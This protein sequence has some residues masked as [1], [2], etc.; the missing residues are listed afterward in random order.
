MN[1]GFTKHRPMS[2]FFVKDEVQNFH[3]FF[4]V[5]AKLGLPLKKV[6]VGHVKVVVMVMVFI[7]RGVHTNIFNMPC[8]H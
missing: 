8:L 5:Y 4:V 1:L 7:G 2:V 3:S 6:Y